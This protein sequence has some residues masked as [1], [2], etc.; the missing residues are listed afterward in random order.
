[1]PAIGRGL[2]LAAKVAQQWLLVTR[3]DLFSSKTCFL[4]SSEHHS[5]TTTHS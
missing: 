5:M 4:L 1:M 2:A 3:V